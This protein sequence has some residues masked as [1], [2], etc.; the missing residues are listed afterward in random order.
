MYDFI[1]TP[2]TAYLVFCYLLYLLCRLACIWHLIIGTDIIT[3]MDHIYTVITETL[4]L[5][6]LLTA[7]LPIFTNGLHYASLILI[8]ILCTLYIIIAVSS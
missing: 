3:Y 6:Y 7:L 5:V 1:T 8:F 4:S 2:H